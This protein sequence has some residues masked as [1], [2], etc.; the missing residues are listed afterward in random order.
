MGICSGKQSSV[1]DKALKSTSPVT[2]YEIKLVLDIRELNKRYERFQSELKRLYSG[3]KGKVSR[4]LFYWL[5]SGS[6][7]S[8]L[9][10]LV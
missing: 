5:G 9:N 6:W 7:Y 3:I 4:S 2:L 8:I 1:N 10:L